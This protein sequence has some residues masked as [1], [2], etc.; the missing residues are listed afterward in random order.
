MVTSTTPSVLIG[1]RLT[2]RAAMGL[3]WIPMRATLLKVLAAVAALLALAGLVALGRMWWDS[4][5]PSTYNVMDVGSHELGG[6]A[7]PAGHHSGGVSVDG[8]KGPQGGAPDARF[9]L[10][11]RQGPI[12]LPSG[13][14]IDALT[15]DGKSPGPELRVRRGDLVEVTLRNG[16]VDTGVTIHWHGVDVPNAE[17]GVAG[18][19]QDAVM[20]GE[21]YTYR[22]RADQLG[23]FWYHSHQV[24]SKQVKRGLYG[25][26]VIEPRT[27]AK[28][29]D[30]AVVA[31][32]FSGR[33]AMGSHDG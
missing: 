30:L 1:P 33:A 20:P 5:L 2:E 23:T 16:D 32:D 6:G 27:K 19:T 14:T 31:H 17:D 22:F 15:F 26:F 7:V 8:L 25:A 10:T 11:A 12:R 3:P 18:V 9:T 24:S 4:R 13:R 21:R 28:G 29:L